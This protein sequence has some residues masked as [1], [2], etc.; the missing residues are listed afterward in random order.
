MI[1][2]SKLFVRQNMDPKFIWH[3][4]S[5][6]ITVQNGEITEKLEG[7]GGKNKIKKTL[8]AKKI[9]KVPL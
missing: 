6:A 3:L 4:M 9:Q 1:L 8:L 2:I 5:A 7:V